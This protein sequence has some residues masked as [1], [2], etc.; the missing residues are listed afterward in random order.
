[1]ETDKSRVLYDQL[2]QLTDLKVQ[3]ELQSGK[4]YAAFSP[5]FITEHGIL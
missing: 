5:V 1:M 4:N 3:I 2:D